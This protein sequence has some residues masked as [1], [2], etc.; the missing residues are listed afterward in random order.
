MKIAQIVV[1]NKC[2]ETDR[3]YSYLIPEGMDLKVGHRVIVP[4]GRAN[5]KIAGYVVGIKNNCDLEVKRLK[6]IAN[7]TCDEIFL[8]SS[9]L[10]IIW[11]MREKYLCYYIEAIH[12][13][14]PASIRIK[15]TYLYELDK[16]FRDMDLLRE[17]NPEV[18]MDVLEFI[19]EN[20]GSVSKEELRDNFNDN[21][22]ENA[23]RKLTKLG[24]IK[25]HQKLKAQESIKYESFIYPGDIK[26]VRINS[27]A[28]KQRMLMDLV[29]SNPGICTTSL[30]REYSIGKQIVESL[31]DKGYI[32]LKKKEVYR[33]MSEHI[34]P[35]DKKVLT[36]EQKRAVKEIREHFKEG[37]HILLHGVTGSGK[38]EIYLELI[39]EELK[40]GKQGIIL[41]PEISLTPQMI[42]RFTGRFGSTVAVLH[43]GL[44]DGEK[45]DEWR[46]IAEG[47]ANVVIG[48]RSA[49][50]APF[51]R[52]GIIIIDEEHE[53]TYKSE[54][55]PKYDAREVAMKRSE[56]E[57][58]SLLLGSATPS[59]E[60]FYKAANNLNNMSLVSINIRVNNRNMPDMKIV[61][62]REELK[63][64]NKSIFSCI[65]S[66]EIKTSLVKKD[67]I[68]LFLNRR[69]YSTF[70]SCRSCGYVA[71]CPNCNISLTY[72]AKGNYLSCHYCGFS[73]SNP[74]ECPSCK[75]KYIK[76]FGIGTQR[77]EKEFKD[78]YGEIKVLRMDADT[79]T[80]KN[81]HREIL[82]KFRNKEASALI[83]T[84]M[85]GKGHDFPDVTL[86]GI[87]TSDTYLNL[88]DFRA[89]EKTFQMV[90]QSAGRAGRGD[91]PGTVII[92]SY[93]PEHYSLLYAQKHDYVGFYNDEIKL[94]KEM[95]YPPFSHLGHIIISGFRE[96]SVIK[97]AKEVNNLFKRLYCC[98][99]GIEIW[100]PSPAPL[101]KINNKHRWQLL[102]KADDENDLLEVM[103]EFN[104]SDIFNTSDVSVSVDIN[105]LNM[106]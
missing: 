5:K 37:R 4:F 82:D 38:T 102:L 15:N 87:I 60:S 89:A 72:H 43:S 93:S 50:F 33:L 27:N 56:I 59:I 64:G 46:R 69:G 55:R 10:K 97:A 105:P 34:L 63:A 91:K 22:L 100:G 52:L 25:R 104:A 9:M 77:V 36:E 1:D 75:S 35:E 41:V 47:K 53:N 96:D 106:L 40:K 6:S 23:I 19:A 14:L 49:I 39:E 30:Q 67:Q 58:A 48:A 61:D 12:G 8:S 81:S 95:N 78:T 71:K 24:A 31:L 54:S 45:Y 101:S 16:D 17:G 98:N 88:P 18:V 83:G 44:S 51:Q 86:V 79:T 32:R 80:R 28:K 76:Y 3:I 85:I 21:L 57:G 92:Q 74:K 103:R 20:G 26:D 2:K 68:I 29:I 11:W 65:L 84:Q 7:L 99:K 73:R 42:R 70:V 62:M 94:R 13:A 66:E 90:T